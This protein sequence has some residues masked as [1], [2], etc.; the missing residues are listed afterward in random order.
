MNSI[1]ITQKLNQALVDYLATTFDANKDGKEAEL[2]R[3]IRESFETPRALFTGPFLELIF[4]YV[5]DASLEMLCQQGVLSRKLLSLPCF[6]QPKPE[7]IPLQVPLYSHQVKS[8]QKLCVEK[9]SIVISS[10]TGSGKTECF[11]IPIVNDLLDDDTPGVRAL[12]VYPLNALVND[13]LDRLRVMLKD[14]PITFG[15]Y[16]SE[17]PQSA[18]RSESMLINEVISRDEIR[19]EKKIP[20]ILI[21]NY[22]MLEY[23]LLRPEDSIIF[24]TGL[25]KYVVLDEA[26]SYTGAQG[27][28]VAMLLRRLKERLGKKPGDMLCIATSATLVNDD[29]GAAANFA[30]NLFC[31]NVAEEDIIFGE[32]NAEH[33]KQADQIGLSISADALLHRDFDNLL[34]EMRKEMPDVEKLALWMVDIGLLDSDVLKFVDQYHSDAPG[35]L[36]QVL[37]NNVELLKLRNWMVER[38][39]PVH[40]EEAARYIFPDYDF[41]DQ[42]KALYH[43][44]ELGATARPAKNQLPLFPAKYHIFARPPQGIWACLNPRC[45]GKNETSTTRWS[46][47][48]SNPTNTC[49]SCGAKV[50]PLYLCRDC[51]QVYIA[52]HYKTNQ[53]MF[54]PA[55]EQLQDGYD[56]RYFTWS[57]IEENIFLSDEVESEDDEDVG[58]NGTYSQKFYLEEVILC[59]NCGRPA[60]N[61]TCKNQIASIP[62]FNLHE[63]KTQKKRGQQIEQRIP[64]VELKECPRCSSKSK[65]DTEIAT[66]ITIRGTGPLANLTYELYRQLPSSPNETIKRLPG[67]GRKL[68]TFY[69]SR[70]GAARFAAFLQDVS[71][72]QN[73]RH[74]IP[75]AIDLCLKE[76][77]WG[78]K[79]A[80][81]LITLS[82][83]CAEIAWKNGIVQNDSDSDFWRN[84]LSFTADKRKEATKWMAKLILGEFTTGRRKRQ[85]LESM[86]LV[87]IS[88]FDELSKPDFRSLAEKIGLSVAQ[89]ETLIGFLLD[90]LRFLK[91]VKLPS[92]ISADDPVFG[93]NKSNPRIIRQGNPGYGE[94]RWIG[95]TPRQSRRQYI[96]FVLEANKV[97]FSDE[98]VVA[99]LTAI[100]D[101]LIREPDGL[102]EG[103]ATDGYQLNLSHILFDTRQNWFRCKK[104]Q[105]LSYRGTS[106]PCPHPHCG[107]EYEPVDITS[108]Q[109]HN[110]FF[111][112]F[113]EDMIPIRVEEHTA[114]LD[115]E[116]GEEY[117]EYFKKGYINVLSCSTTFEMGIDLGDLQAVAMS[118]VPPTVA[119]YRQRAGRAGRR[120]SGTAFIL[121]WASDR[122]H[123]QAYY[124][125]PTEIIS[126]QVAVPNIMLENELILYRHVNAILLSKFLR[127]R[128]QQGVDS[129]KL[130]FTGDFFDTNL[131]EA[132]HYSF[133]QEWVDENHN[134]IQKHLQAFAYLLPEE[135]RNLVDNGIEHFLSDLR[136]LNE[137][138]YQPVTQYYKEQIQQ[139]AERLGDVS[140]SSQSSQEV[141]K[142]LGYYRGLLERIRGSKGRNSGYLI[143]YLSN[144]GVLP[145]YSF[146]L[147]TVELMLPREERQSE[148][149]RLERDL[150]QAIREYAPGSE[151]VADKKVWRSQRPIFWKDTPKILEYR[152]CEY[153][154]HLDISEDAGVPLAETDGICSVCNQPFGRKT[155][156]RRFVEPDGFIADP[157]SGKPAK[158]FVNIEPNQMRSALIPEQNLVEEQH[159]KFIYLS[160][161]Q[162]GK[163]LYVNEGKFG[164]GFPISLQGFSLLSEKGDKERLSLGHIQTTNTLHIR[165]TGNEYLQIPSPDDQSFW[166]SLLS[167]I[168]HGASHCLQIERRDI[169]GVLFPR[170]SGGSWDQTIVLY[171]N[172]P[173][174]AGHVKSIRENLTFVLEEARRILN[175]N[176]CAPDT[177]CYHCL[178]DYNNQY[179]HQYLQRDAALKFLD[180]LIADLEPLDVGVPGAVRIVASDSASWLLEKIRYS[181]QSVAL[182]IPALDL[183]HP[184][185]ENYSWL[186]TLGDLIKKEC[187]VDLCLKHLPAHT[188]EGYSL[189][190]HLQVLMNK[191]LKVWKI[192]QL[193][194]W[195]FIIDPEYTESRIIGTELEND[196]IVLE[197]GIGTHRLLSTTHRDA[198]KSVWDEWQKNPK[199][200][201][202]PSELNPPQ[203]VKVI[204]LPASARSIT[205]EQDLFGE[206]FA[207]P[208]KKLLV[209]DPYL[210]DRERIVRRLGAYIALAA[211]QGSLDEVIVHTK[212]A[213]DRVEQAKSEQELNHKFNGI[214]RF[215]HSVDHDRFIEVT[216][217]DGEKARIIIGRGLDFIQSDGSTKSTYI[218]IQDP[219]D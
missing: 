60:L 45:P 98:N 110:Y 109:Q 177:S 113:Q 163:L 217:L 184:Q 28:E 126:G 47:L 41:P 194:R 48:F 132:P 111:N 107:G 129:E 94:I 130:T 44:I 9:R 43:L 199:T 104:C 186:D 150:R 105:R 187:K 216:R 77:E 31:E 40:V 1:K 71:N 17:L 162:K 55:V 15:R 117:Q 219:V 155:R 53:D 21:T 143:S 165:F 81:S 114:Q 32:E 75:H 147:H 7:P 148:H 89:T 61:C 203:H 200:S 56:K 65:N 169:D 95:A 136:R 153:C 159:S 22:A 193:P 4:P 66:P 5:Q 133:L 174:G 160:Y 124:D 46:R 118:N 128:L 80:P 208:C 8:I 175:C 190:S 63:K 33:F 116:K 146:P 26:H 137:E 106:V 192:A 3:K 76:D 178:R 82:K 183:R 29:A 42:M 99:V 92:G 144:N 88:Y 85:S 154:H 97:D 16:T 83:R 25:W 49:D 212:L 191:G 72:K 214:I 149:L 64:L 93:A 207:E 161:N 19:K 115:S 181:R 103:S 123:D 172:V 58:E 35:F 198:V 202:D 201:V 67:E 206:F 73:Y 84:S 205:T 10:G 6:T 62:L 59:L 210:F 189:A 196:V 57:K 173:G 13:Q 68:L 179:Y 139:L 188:P 197:D 182:A 138:H 142:Q 141:H 20:Q 79:T 166:L 213:T 120:T 39:K 180:L 151:I 100:W 134:E 23:L 2:A 78:E 18:D 87:G 50:F 122:P 145:S 74:I 101:W 127:Y 140:A 27:I 121:T 170:S 119:N 204:N 51:G 125:N 185:G 24:N 211:R 90:D 34:D 176:D 195:Q 158:Q 70:Q 152:I 11:S 38:A 36:Y 209:H 218:V 86:G 168:I 156:R 96:K 69:D 112:L 91:A 12:L 52:A 37:S 131:S 14:T 135:L 164:K 102:F 157:K 108:I 171:D 167:A 30:Q 54:L 215:K